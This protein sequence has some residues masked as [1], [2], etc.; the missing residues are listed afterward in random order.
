VNLASRTTADFANAIA[1]ALALVDAN[2]APLVFE[3]PRS[4]RA[5]DALYTR[6][7][8]ALDS[9]RPSKHAPSIGELVAVLVWSKGAPPTK[10]RWPPPPETRARRDPSRRAL[11]E[12]V[13]VVA[14]G[15]F[16]RTKRAERGR[17]VAELLLLFDLESLLD[18]ELGPTDDAEEALRRVRRALAAR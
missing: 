15:S 9:R 12:L 16:E 1:R 5:L 10:R 2:G 17:V 14:Q 18:V 3:E 11:A 13:E 7:G 4:P 6:F 8:A